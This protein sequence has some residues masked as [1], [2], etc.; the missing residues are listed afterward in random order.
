MVA[1]FLSDIS[2]SDTPDLTLPG[3][4]GKEFCGPIYIIVEMDSEHEISENDEIN[5]VMPS[6]ITINCDIGG[7]EGNVILNKFTSIKYSYT[8]KVATGNNILMDVEF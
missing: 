8:D 2:L 5:N 4:L 1:C 3:S 6:P 7:D